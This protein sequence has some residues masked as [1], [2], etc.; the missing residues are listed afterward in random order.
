MDND[1]SEL[2][3]GGISD[4]NAGYRTHLLIETPVNPT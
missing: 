3:R 1:A 2:N 4:N